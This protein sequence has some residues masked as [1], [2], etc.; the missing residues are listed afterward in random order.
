MDDF[1]L[2]MAKMHRDDLLRKAEQSRRAAQARCSLRTRRSAGETDGPVARSA[3]W[4][5]AA[6]GRMRLTTAGR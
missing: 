4:L 5:A 2:M 3:H 1:K 6:A